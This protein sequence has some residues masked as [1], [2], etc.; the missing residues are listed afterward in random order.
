MQIRMRREKLPLGFADLLSTPT[1]Q[2]FDIFILAG[3]R[4]FV[5][6]K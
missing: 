1:Q 5:E 3:F 4:K 6:R 2:S